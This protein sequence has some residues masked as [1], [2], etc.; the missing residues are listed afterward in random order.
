MKPQSQIDWSKAPVW[1]LCLAAFLSPIIGGTISTDAMALEPGYASTV[2]AI[3]G[4]AEVPILSHLV[5]ATLVC[6]SAVWILLTRRV[7][8]A[9][10]PLIGYAVLGLAIFIV[11]SCLLTSF[12]AL[13]IPT[14]LEWLVY[15]IA[16]LTAI[17]GI[18]RQQGPVSV[19]TALFAGCALLS[20]IGL[21]EYFFET[22]D[23]S[24]RIFGTWQNPN[25]M[26]GMLLIGLFVGAGLTMRPER[27]LAIVAGIGTVAI[28]FA[29]A[30]TQSKGAFLA[31]AVGLAALLVL[32]LLWLRGRAGAARLGRV[33]LC[34]VALIG[35]LSLLRLQP[36]EPGVAAAPLA[37]VVESSTT[38]EQSSGFRMLLWKG[39]A[40]L[41]KERPY[42]WGIGSYRH[43]SG[44]PGLTTQTQLAHNSYL[45]LGAEAG[46]GAALLLAALL[47]LWAY[48]NFKGAVRQTSE[49]VALKLGLVAAV[50]AAAAHNVVD[51][52][53]YYFGS[54]LA[55]FLLLGIGFQLNA[56]GVTP[57][58]V[59]PSPRWVAFSLAVLAPLGLLYFGAIEATKAHLRAD[60][61]A[62][63]IDSAV[64]GG[65]ALAASAMRDGDAWYMKAMVA[66]SQEERRSALEKA[67]DLTPS[68]RNLRAYARIQ[69]EAGDGAGATATFREALLRDPNNLYTLKALL[70][71]HIENEAEPEAEAIAKRM[72]EVEKSTYFQ[73]R[74]LPELVPAETTFARRYLAA[75][76]QDMAARIDLLTPAVA[77]LSDYA[78]RT[79]PNVANSVRANMRQGYAGETAAIA[80]EKVE[81][82]KLL[83][84]AL[85]QAR[86][87]IGDR[88]GADEA[89][90]KIP[91]FETARAALDEAEAA[92]TQTP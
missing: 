36:S 44:R 90:A 30:L 37:R 11:A 52:D 61:A 78:A 76:T 62:G 17:G 85:A 7:I 86:E 89:R 65:D 18:G 2:Q 16:L 70:D 45:Q 38:Q 26:A 20:L 84:A 46:V 77:I 74:A 28:A 13:S 41:I 4:G 60:L 10:M 58:S 19:L 47:G 51:S 71:H 81:L 21:N 35:L 68:T 34:L 6:A 53:L 15:L 5:I 54:G 24:W 9:P 27:G 31:A 33:A 56:D 92:A 8:Q 59:Q 82:G 3:F 12:P 66:Q 25:A 50:A 57:E 64:A 72:I 67:A 55:F 91:A 42:G 48:Y 32:G 80:R 29:L 79:V 49:A 73:I 43:E 22:A 88:A 40:E 63:R 87:S 83:T 69:Q 1:L 39:A 75:K 14:A 23:P